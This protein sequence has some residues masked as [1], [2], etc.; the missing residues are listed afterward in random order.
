MFAH[1]LS[2]RRGV[3]YGVDVEEQ[4]ASIIPIPD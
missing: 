2:L 1:E 3:K 4:L